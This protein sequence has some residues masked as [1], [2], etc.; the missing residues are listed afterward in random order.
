MDTERTT[1]QA[2][3][4]VTHLIFDAGWQKCVIRAAGFDDVFEKRV[5]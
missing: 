4:V 2:G 1:E 5:K 3:D